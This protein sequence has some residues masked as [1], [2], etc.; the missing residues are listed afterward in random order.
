LIFIDH[1]KDEYLPDFKLLEQHGLIKKGTVI[2]ADN[3]IF[4]GCPDYLEY[5]RG[6]K[7]YKTTLHESFLEYTNDMKDGVEVSTRITD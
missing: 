5:V 6:N 2:V 1:W 3:C 7:N 4:P